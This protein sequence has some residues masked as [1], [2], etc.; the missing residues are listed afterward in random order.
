M[1][2]DGSS[3]AALV[4]RF[5]ARTLGIPGLYA[6]LNCRLL[7]TNHIVTLISFAWCVD[8]ILHSVLFCHVSRASKF[9]FRESRI[10]INGNIIK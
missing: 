1:D 9:D 4:P 8:V 5:I 10:I 3:G 2:T 6:K 7:S